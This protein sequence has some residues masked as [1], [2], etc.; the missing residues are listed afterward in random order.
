MAI[1][2]AAALA[3]F[4]LGFGMIS[5]RIEKSI[6]TPPMVFVTFGLGISPLMLQ[7]I[8]VNHH[9]GIIDIIATTTLVMVLFTDSSRI[10]LKLLRRQ[11]TLPVRLLGVGLPITIGLGA[12]VAWLLFPSFNSW[13]A[14]AIAAILA[15][16]DAAL[17]QAVVSSPS[18]PVRIRQALNVESGLNDG[19]CL[20]ILLMALSL[21]SRAEGGATAGYWLSFAL[22][23]VLLGPVAGIGVGFIGGGLVSRSARLH[24]MNENYQRLSLVAIA[25]L[26]YCGAELIGGNGFIAAF[27]AGL[28]LGNTARVVCPRLYEFG[29]TEGQFLVLVT[30]LIYGGVMITPTMVGANGAVILYALLS[31]TLVRMIGVAIS[32]L[33]LSLRFDTQLF[34]GWFGP[35]GIA[36]V[37]YV[38][39]VLDQDGLPN[40]DLI[41]TIVVVTVL[42]SVFA[43]GVTAFSGANWYARRMNSIQDTSQVVEH[44]SVDE[45]P[46]RT[47]YR[48]Q[49][50]EM[51]E[52]SASGVNLTF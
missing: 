37:L 22:A 15:P 1:A 10:D 50:G 26:A 39:L 27:C 4:T 12:V 52:M 32:L 38:L 43:H 17:G 9:G 7:V 46:V 49:H 21:A 48:A 18:V 47:P 2:I 33:G 28:T 34:L 35:R 24:W 42:L 45:M 8:D 36:S 14:V 23:Q 30:F 5:G 25:V 31:L 16:T 20:P 29:E 44:D 40:R 13:E 19:I 6:L 11:H 3:L 41:F 51:L